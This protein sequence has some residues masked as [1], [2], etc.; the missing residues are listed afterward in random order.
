M[1]SKNQ[2]VMARKAVE[3]LYEGTCEI[4]EYQKYTRENKS[5][6]YREVPVAEDLPCQLSYRRKSGAGQ[7][8][9]VAAVDQEITVLMAPEIVIRPGSKLVITQ[10]GATEAYQCSGKPAVYQ[11]HQEI[12]LE[13]FGGWS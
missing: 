10:N 11:T 6:G 1:L 7:T 5:T 8:D 2:V 4:V 9:A 13:L 3:K 12:Y